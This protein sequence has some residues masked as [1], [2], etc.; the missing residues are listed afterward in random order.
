MFKNASIFLFTQSVGEVLARIEECLP[1]NP[2]RPLG[3][4]GAKSSG[5]FSWNSDEYLLK[6]SGRYY[7][8]LKI[9]EKK[10][11]PAAIDE[12]LR[13]KIKRIEDANS[14]IKVGKKDRERIKAEIIEEFLPHTPPTPSFIDAYVDPL[15]GI[16]VVD[17]GSA[18]KADEF[19]ANLTPALGG[20]PFET[21]GISDD[22]SSKL[23]SWLKYPHNLG[24]HFSLGDC[25]SLKEPGKD[26]AIVNIQ[27]DVLSGD[28]IDAHLEAGKVCVRLGLKRKGSS[29]AID[30]DLRLRSLK[31]D[32][33]LRAEFSDVEENTAA[34][35]DAD[36]II[37]AEEIREI[38][39]SLEFLAGPFPRQ[40]SMDLPQGEKLEAVEK[41][42]P[43]PPKSPQKSDGE[44]PD[45]L[46]GKAILFVRGGGRATGKGLRDHFGIGSDRAKKLL[47]ALKAGGY[48]S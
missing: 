32:D 10:I 27:K 13:D 44:K 4:K 25:C 1:L 45:P 33:A 37:A 16:L 48:A 23:T 8:R 41:K 40:S 3:A 46:L 47:A 20:C 15:L 12:I 36:R 42:A 38:F 26:P 22:P 28:E 29:F 11:P 35:M 6:L 24:N 21:L 30:T 9:H 19:L 2:F 39:Y 34:A 7:F 31:L 18:G 43:E 5:F 14:E 17:A